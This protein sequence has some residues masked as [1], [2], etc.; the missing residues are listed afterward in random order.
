MK[1]YKYI[2]TLSVAGLVF[3]LDQISKTYVHT[4]MNVGENY[5]IINGFF[6]ITYIRNF[7]GAFGLFKESHDIIRYLLL[8]CLPIIAIFIIFKLLNETENKYQTLAF[9]FI[10]G[11]AVGNYFDRIR[12]GYVIDFFD[13][14]IKNSFHWPIF[15]IADIFIVLGVFILSLFYLFID[16]PK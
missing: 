16:K 3:A 9:G 14:H 11:G 5:K 8:F 4:Q 7:G 10:L 2:L 12:L 15:N 13:L 6:D 1:M